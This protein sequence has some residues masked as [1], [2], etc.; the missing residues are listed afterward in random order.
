MNNSK[1]ARIY[2][3]IFVLAS[4]L[5]VALIGQ[6]Q[7]RPASI[8]I[9]VVKVE[10]VSQDEVHFKLNIHNESRSPVF[11]ESS[12]ELVSTRLPNGPGDT[13]IP[14]QL[15]LERWQDGVWHQIV[16]CL[17]N[18]PSSVLKLNPGKTVSQDRVLTD[19]VESPCKDRHVRLEGT[20]RFRL[21]YFLSEREAKAN[22]SNF[23]TSG[24]NLPAPRVA[25]S[26]SFEIPLK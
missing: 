16:P 26:A 8:K 18:A 4:C 1:L 2:L 19:P 9:I 7:P 25:V 23:D 21:E 11:L 5:S 24:A 14:E 10:R 6:S 20:F 22:E 13:S 17:E 12:A 15:Y 3:C